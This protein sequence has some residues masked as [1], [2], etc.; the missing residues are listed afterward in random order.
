L[1]GFELRA[2]PVPNHRDLSRQVRELVHKLGRAQLGHEDLHMGNFLLSEGKVYLLDAYAVRPGGLKLTDTL[3]LAQS[4]GRFGTRTDLLRGWRL[5]ISSD[6]TP[7][8][9]NRVADSVYASFI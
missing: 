8:A 3:R 9:Q 5:L 6:A 7:P 4:A 1:N 2:E